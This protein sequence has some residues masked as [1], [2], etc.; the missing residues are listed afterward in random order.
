MPHERV[1]LAIRSRGAYTSLAAVPRSLAGLGAEHGV[2]QD[3]A[4]DA[5]RT[6]VRILQRMRLHCQ[7]GRRMHHASCGV[8]SRRTGEAAQSVI[9]SSPIRKSAWCQVDDAAVRASMLLLAGGGAGRQLVRL[10]QLLQSGL[11]GEVSGICLRA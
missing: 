4:P 5:S 2:A 6:Q 9:P 3:G 11:L 8:T 1:Q 10:G 7:S